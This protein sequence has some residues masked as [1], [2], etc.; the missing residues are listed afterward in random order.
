MALAT[1]RSGTITER[2]RAILMD[3][4]FC[5]YLSTRQIEYLFFPSSGKARARLAKLAKKGYIANRTMYIVEPTSWEERAAAQGVWHL[6]KAG[7]DS[8][9]EAL[10]VDEAYASKL[11][12]PKQARHYVRTAEVYAAAKHDLDAELEPYPEWEWRHEKRV[13]YAGEYRNVPYQH[14]PDTH[15]IFRGHT[16]ILERQTAE[17]RIG[18]KKIYA[19]VEDHKRYVEL[20]LKASAEVLF[21]FDKDDSTLIGEAERAGKQYGIRVVGGSVSRIAEYLYSSAV[22]LY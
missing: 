21:A 18:P 13:L 17:S 15:I 6:T 2:D 1:G 7:F 9:A 11:L 16:F 10:G 5:R 3:L 14:K 8:V 12:L 4:Y 19:K 20:R 22:R